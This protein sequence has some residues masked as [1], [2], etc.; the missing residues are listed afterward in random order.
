M[1]RTTIAAVQVLLYSSTEG[2]VFFFSFSES[3]LKSCLVCKDE[4]STQKAHSLRVKVPHGIGRQ[5]V[6]DFR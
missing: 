1:D 6:Y 4:K 2:H 5:N 3:N